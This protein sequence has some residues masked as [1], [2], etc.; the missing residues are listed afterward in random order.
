MADVPSISPIERQILQFFIEHS[1]AV[2]TVRGMSTWLGAEPEAI[3][4]ALN[5]LVEKKWLS[6]HA[7]GALTG[8][9][10]TSE[11]RFVSQIKQTLELP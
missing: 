5:G 8:Y 6:S 1:N 4:S 9:T 7:A 10:L 3:E 11:E 2:E